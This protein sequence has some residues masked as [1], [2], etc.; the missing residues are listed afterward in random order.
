MLPCQ[1]FRYGGILCPAVVGVTN[2]LMARTMDQGLTVV[3][4]LHEPAAL[5]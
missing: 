1:C 2:N 4:R 5:E 3:Q